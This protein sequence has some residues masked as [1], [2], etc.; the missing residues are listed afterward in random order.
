MSLAGFG[1]AVAA[2]PGFRNQLFGNTTNVSKK[3][4]T[5]FSDVA[6]LEDAKLKFKEIAEFFSDNVKEANEDLEERR[7]IFKKLGV[8]MRKGV[9]LHGPSG[10]GKTL[11]ARALA[12]EAG[13]NF[14]TRNA[15][16]FSS[17]YAG[18][19][20]D[21]VHQLFAEA[22]KLQ[23]CVIFI[24]E[25]DSIGSRAKDRRG[26]TPYG[27][28]RN[29]TINQ[30]LVEM[31]GFDDR[32]GKIVVIAATNNVSVVDPA[33]LRFGRFD[34]KIEV[35]LPSVQERTAILLKKLES[36]K[37]CITLLT[38]EEIAQKSEKLSGAD[39]ENIVN[40][41]GYI[42]VSKQL[43]SVDDQCLEK[44]FNATPR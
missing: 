43:E 36:L 33:I 17:K 38:I 40:E 11:L 37:N 9:L 35:R 24:D 19:G 25:I 7:D 2:F 27:L 28:D 29:N 5:K 41:A 20:A 39:L 22:E 13:V 10:T 30:L 4:T 26:I 6:G 42:A 23:P 16:E 12:G 34:L 31:D 32:R 1:A 3:I 8:K 44:A 18:V 15:S 21:K 14:V